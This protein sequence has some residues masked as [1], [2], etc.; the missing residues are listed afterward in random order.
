MVSYPLYFL[1][2]SSI[3]FSLTFLFFYGDDIDF[4]GSATFTKLFKFLIGSTTLKW[5]LFFYKKISV[6]WMFGLELPSIFL[7]LRNSATF[8]IGDIYFSHIFSLK[9]WELIFLLDS[10]S[11]EGDSLEWAWLIL[12]ESSKF[13]FFN[14]KAASG[15]LRGFLSSILKMKAWSSGV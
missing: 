5:L 1:L 10:A 12:W 13:W 8:F 15:L 6:L 3:Y 7:W 4:L 2:I 11:F 14:K 9:N